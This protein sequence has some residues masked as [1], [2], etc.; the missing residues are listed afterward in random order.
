MTGLEKINDRILHEA[1]MQAKESMQNAENQ[2]A[3]LLDAAR[4]EAEEKRNAIINKAKKD[5]QEVKKRIIAAAELEA[6]K[7]R[8]RAK[9]EL[10]E[11]T[12]SRVLHQLVNMPE[13]QYRQMLASMIA[14]AAEEEEFDILLSSRDRERLGEALLSD[15]VSQLAA[16]GKNAKLKMAVGNANIQGGFILR[17]GN[18]EMNYSFEAMMRMQQDELEQLIC[19]QLF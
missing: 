2:A 1:Q 19:S 11:E 5:A 15:A 8:L 10:V 17:T 7:Q 12:L 14:D 4:S 9:Q 13:I 6:R 16:R 3:V 18:I